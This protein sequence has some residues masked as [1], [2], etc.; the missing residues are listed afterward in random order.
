MRRQQVGIQ[1]VEYALMLIVGAVAAFVVARPLALEVIDVFN[2][3]ANA[4]NR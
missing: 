3:L 4:L 1:S 2:Q